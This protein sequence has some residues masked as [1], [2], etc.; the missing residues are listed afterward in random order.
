MQI[1]DYL[2]IIERKLSE[3]PERQEKS[4]EFEYNKICPLESDNGVPVTN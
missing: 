1:Q 4:E 3:R 2:E